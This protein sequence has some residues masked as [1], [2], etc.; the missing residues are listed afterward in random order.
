MM[1]VSVLRLPDFTKQFII[2]V[3]AS[4]VG[5]GVVLMQEGHPIAYFS[6]VL[7]PL[8]RSKVVYEREFMA[9]VMA[10]QKW[11][12]YLLGRK[13]LV[14]TNQ[15]SL[16]F[17][18]EQRLVAREYQKLL[19]KLM[20]YD[21]DIVYKPQIEN[22]VVDALS[23]LPNVVEFAAVSVLGDLNTGLITDQQWMMSSSS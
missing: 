12:P 3:D 10:V 13:F 2:E 19:T 14:R 20:G 17:I 18:L 4:G 7:S 9:I 8:H 11:R 15:I 5:V 21:F 1:T 23:R 6:H 16:K 22:K